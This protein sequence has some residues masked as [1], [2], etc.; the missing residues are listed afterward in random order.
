MN[1]TT[2]TWTPPP[3]LDLTDFDPDI[4]YCIEVVNITCGEG[5]EV[6]VSEC[7]ITEPVYQSRDIPLHYIYNITVT[8][9]SNV[10]GAMNGTNTTLE[11]ELSLR[12][13]LRR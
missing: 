5:G 1:T 2:I 12:R 9:M 8:P 3:S 11:G 4:V 13:L 7:G 6:L 10:E